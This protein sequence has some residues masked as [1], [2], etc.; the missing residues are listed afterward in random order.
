MSD[1]PCII[2]IDC[3][4][5]QIRPNN[6]LENIFSIL[7]LNIQVPEK[8]CAVFGSWIFEFNNPKDK[9]TLRTFQDNIISEL[10]SY[11]PSVIRYA[12]WK[13]D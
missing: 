13:F 7:N 1:K 9:D 6:V 8:S 11:Y 10:K 12:S 5:G 2:E 3:P 4:P